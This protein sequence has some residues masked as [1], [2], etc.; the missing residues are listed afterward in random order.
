MMASSFIHPDFPH[1]WTAEILPQRP[2]ILPKR[3][4]VYPR[5]AEEV[6][7][8]AL[9]VLVRPAEGEPFLATCALG[10][11]DPAA[12]SGI[13]SCPNPEW[14]CAVSGGYAYLID[15]T[16]PEH[17]AQIEYRPVLE[18][19]GLPEQRLLLFVGH[20]S[21]LA[22]GEHGK[23]WQTTRL[24]SEGV[25]VTDIEGDVLRGMGWDLM[26]DADV[27]FAIDLRTGERVDPSP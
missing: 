5:Q 1:H 2:L 12:P 16:L 25:T 17:F 24:S 14:V 20:H 9:E 7:R 18:V 3:Q 19:R 26:S 10:F 4:F 6:E 11:A 22:W 21:L 23:A 8:G 15:T 27:P 13:W